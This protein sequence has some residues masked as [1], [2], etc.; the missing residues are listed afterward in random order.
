[1]ATFRKLQ[2]SSTRDFPVPPEPWSLQSSSDFITLEAS[3]VC[4]SKGLADRQISSLRT[5][6]L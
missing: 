5:S 1:M 4:A 3:A 6:F 2:L